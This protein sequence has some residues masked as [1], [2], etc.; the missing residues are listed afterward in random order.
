MGT[1]V[2]FPPGRW[3]EV[4]HILTTVVDLSREQRTEVLDDRCG[5]DVALRAEVESL[6]HAHDT[7]GEFVERRRS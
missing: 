7:A 2:K 5:Q 6:L 3:A 4:K 1:D